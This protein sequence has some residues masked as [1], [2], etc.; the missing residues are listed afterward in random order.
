MLLI[1]PT[2][3][4]LLMALKY[5]DVRYKDWFKYIY[6][7]LL[8]L[9]IIFFI[10]VIIISSK[11]IRPISYIVLAVLI[12]IFVLLFILSLSKKKNVKSKE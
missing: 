3:I 1:S 5:E 6:K 12:V 7:F 8:G 2:S 9:L 11:Y 10:V 4:V